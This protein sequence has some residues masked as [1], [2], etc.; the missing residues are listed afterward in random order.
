MS[1]LFITFEGIDFSGKTEQTRQL[2]ET[3]R[4]AGYEVELLREPGGVKIAEAIRAIL[5]DAKHAGMTERTELLL[6]SAA[7][8]QI[9]KER[10]QP[11][12]A[13]G[14][15]VLA[16]RFADSTTAYQGYGRQ[17]DLDFVRSINRFA[18]W[19][20]SPT[21][22]FFLDISLSTAEARQR[23][24]GKTVDRLESENRAFHERVQQ[25]YW[26]LV[27]AEPE[28]FVVIDGEQ[29]LSAISRQINETL[30]QRFGLK[31]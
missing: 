14:K 24:S 1:G 30:R 13:A 18:T 12:L 21:L 28:R 9:T 11:A 29:S 10:I 4:H 17:I 2:A 19:E 5:L 22:T 6:Y 15:I 16:D 26:Q 8:A 31:I 23:H 25:G 7:R 20:I 27:K 3:L